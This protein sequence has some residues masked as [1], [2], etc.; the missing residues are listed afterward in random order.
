MFTKLTLKTNYFLFKQKLSHA[1]K[2][3]FYFEKNYFAFSPFNFE[4]STVKAATVTAA[5]FMLHFMLG[6]ENNIG[7][8]HLPA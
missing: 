1:E 8:H 3:A 6:Y 2:H 7:F 4:T 5:R